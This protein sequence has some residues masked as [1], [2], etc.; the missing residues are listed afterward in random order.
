M[1]SVV[2]VQQSKP[3]VGDITIRLTKSE[4]Q[5]LQIM[6]D[7]WYRRNWTSNP[8]AKRDANPTYKALE[9]A[10]TGKA[11]ADAIKINAFL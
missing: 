5:D 3:R 10:L 11:P 2:E 9:S 4:A 6:V 7:E 1:A 8:T